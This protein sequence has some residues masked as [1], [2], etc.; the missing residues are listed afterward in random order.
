[1]DM[2]DVLLNLCKELEFY[3]NSLDKVSVTKDL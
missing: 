1:M 3:S 2:L